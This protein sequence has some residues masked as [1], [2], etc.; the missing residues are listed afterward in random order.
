MHLMYVVKR[1]PQRRGCRTV[2]M[3]AMNYHRSEARAAVRAAAPF[4]YL[5]DALSTYTNSRPARVS[6]T[7]PLASRKWARLSGRRASASAMCMAVRRSGS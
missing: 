2:N 7:P 1:A 4:Q 6:A 3:L 5:Y